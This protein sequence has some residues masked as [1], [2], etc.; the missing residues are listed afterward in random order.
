MGIKLRPSIK[1]FD[2]NKR[3]TTQH[4][5]IKCVSYEDLVTARKTCQPKHKNKIEKE[6][7]IRESRMK[8]ASTH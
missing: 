1:V 8:L 2:K 3:K 4:T 7:A 6:L 5:Y